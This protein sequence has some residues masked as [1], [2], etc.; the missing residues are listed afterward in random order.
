MNVN[1][2][3]LFKRKKHRDK[4][5]TLV[6]LVVAMALTA[7]LA[8]AVVTVMH[9]AVSIFLNVQKHSRAQM[10]ADTVADTLRAECASSYIK[11]YG[12]ARVISVGAENS[13]SEGDNAIFS[14]LNGL[15]TQSE[16]DGNVLFIRKNEGYAEVLYCNAW[17]SQGDYADV[18]A[19]DQEHKTDDVTS[20]AVYRLFPNVTG[21]LDEKQMPIDT[22]QGYLHSAYYETAS[23][24]LDIDGKTVTV[25]HP[26]KPYDY[27]N[28]FA[29]NV[30]SG[31]TVY[32][33]YSDFTY[34]SIVAGSDS[35]ADKRP[36]YVVANIKVYDSGFG[37]QSIDT[38]VYSRQAV[39]CF[40]QDN[41][42]E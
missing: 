31:F 7:I 15:T 36:A 19:I 33:T 39:L 24:K 30:Y 9:P 1:M 42:K 8:T 14:A 37:E 27:T 38:L 40:A 3:K 10:V 32:V 34:E 11:G 2:F 20:K 26:A 23:T 21:T 35:L 4:G 17:I 6:E 16:S 12:D 22:R 5:S 25:V 29:S 13:H 41:V 28:P 18:Y